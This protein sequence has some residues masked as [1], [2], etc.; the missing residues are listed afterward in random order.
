[1]ILIDRVN[2]SVYF[3]E[4]ATA[5]RFRRYTPNTRAGGL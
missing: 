3:Y 4:G 2:L 5:P 1:M